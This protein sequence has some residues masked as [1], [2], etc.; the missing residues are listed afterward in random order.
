VVA[1]LD[2]GHKASDLLNRLGYA[3]HLSGEPVPL[4]QNLFVFGS[5]GASFSSASNSPIRTR[6]RFA[7]S[8]SRSRLN[9]ASSIAR[10][11]AIRS[12]H[13]GRLD[14]NEQAQDSPDTASSANTA[15]IRASR[16]SV[17]SAALGP[18]SKQS[19]W[20]WP[21]TLTGRPK[22]VFRLGLAAQH[23]TQRFER[24]PNRNSPP[25]IL[26]RESH[27]EGKTRVT[28]A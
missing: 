6:S 24:I 15:T 8:A 18:S 26:L 20:C 13:R 14:R 10:R 4:G 1:R 17:G 22:L 3:P 5:L 2:L 19:T 28:S 21:F 27:R 9:A 16:S 11:A 7:A 12:T 25:A 23:A